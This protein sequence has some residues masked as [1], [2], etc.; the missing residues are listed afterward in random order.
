[1]MEPLSFRFDGFS[2]EVTFP[3]ALDCAALGSSCPAGCI[4]VFDATTH[5][6]FGAGAPSA[7]VLPAGEVA[8]KWESAQTILSFMVDRGLGRDGMV[9]AV[10]GGVVSDLAAFAA[11]IYMR[12]CGLTLVP[13]TLL[14]MV[15][16]SMGG[17]TGIDFAGYKNLVG[18]FYPAS[19]IIVYAAVLSSLPQR[20]YLSGLAE[21][22]KTAMIGDRI[23]LEALEGRRSEVMARDPAFLADVVR[24]CLAVKGE[25]VSADMREEGGRAVLNLGHTFAHAL[26]S[27]MG[28]AGWTHGE[29]VAWG[30]SKALE[31]GIALGMTERGYAEGVVEM[32]E[33][34]G[35]RLD[36]DA[37]QRDLAAAMLMDKKRRRGR[38]RLAVPRSAGS[39][40]IVEVEEDLIARVLSARGPESRKVKR[41][42]HGR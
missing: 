42:D 32:L 2:T 27:C 3:D 41:S 5:A 11:S 9:I 4:L 15:D 8:K 14:A 17:K 26:E 28:F 39:V 7:V 31:A 34:Y 20:E 30:I 24:R 40:E 37:N 25:V 10:G 33:G 35:Y 29:A 23:L 16:A 22:I 38:I 18:T 13:T 1:M 21:A 6:L 12:G 19:R 36:T